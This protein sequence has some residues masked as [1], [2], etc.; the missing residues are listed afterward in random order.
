MESSL[1]VPV[2]ALN[3]LHAHVGVGTVVPVDTPLALRVAVKA[4]L[5]ELSVRAFEITTRLIFPVDDMVVQDA[6]GDS[7]AVSVVMA[8]QSC[9]SV[10]VFQ[11]CYEVA[12]YKTKKTF[13]MESS[14]KCVF[15]CDKIVYSLAT[16]AVYVHCACSKLPS[17]SSICLPV[18]IRMYSCPFKKEL[19]TNEVRGGSTRLFLHDGV[20][21]LGCT[22]SAKRWKNVLDHLDDCRH[23]PETKRRERK[24]AKRKKNKLV[25]VSCEICGHCFRNKNSYFKH[26]SRKHPLQHAP[27]KKPDLN[28][29]PGI[30]PIN[31]EI[32]VASP[33]DTWSVAETSP[34]DA[35]STAETGDMSLLLELI[36]ASEEG[37][38]QAEPERMKSD[39]AHDTNA[40]PK[41]RLRRRRKK[42]PSL[43]DDVP[44]F[45]FDD[46]DRIYDTVRDIFARRTFDSRQ[47]NASIMPV[48]CR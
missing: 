47:E 43:D 42:L 4:K 13:K 41:R 8:L 12:D 17:A 1:A 3:E 24:Q 36:E 15:L 2:G 25:D 30:V 19:D 32:P 35:C 37:A 6:H 10:D 27:T 48:S 7:D 9:G 14:N 40:R 5:Q 38:Q 20:G 23:N 16:S 46:R 31:F 45:S 11:G 29:L 34:V 26:K 18:A 39:S 21:G 22:Y 33:V 44:V 28:A